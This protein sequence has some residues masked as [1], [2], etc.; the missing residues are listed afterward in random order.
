MHRMS[1]TPARSRGR[2]NRMDNG[3]TRAASFK[4][5]ATVREQRRTIVAVSSGR[6]GVL[7]KRVTN[8]TLDAC[9]FACALLA[10]GAPLCGQGVKGQI[11]GTITDA[12]G[13][14]VR[15]VHVTAV[16]VES[17]FERKTLT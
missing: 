7:F 10:C 14:V 3:L 13:G 8:A 11:S 6:V 9:Y 16:R 5:A 15:S 1:F 4:A 12:S 17:G 2:A